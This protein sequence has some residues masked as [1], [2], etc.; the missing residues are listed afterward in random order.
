M[1]PKAKN[2][3]PNIKKIQVIQNF[4]AEIDTP[5]NTMHQE[6]FNRLKPLTLS[7]RYVR[8]RLNYSVSLVVRLVEEYREGFES[9][10]IEYPTPLCN[11]YIEH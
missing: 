9:R 7:E 4:E 8:A 2:I 3:K 11:C 10:Y 6:S 1:G 5:S